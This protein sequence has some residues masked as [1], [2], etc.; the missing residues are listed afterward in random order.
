MYIKQQ[1]SKSRSR[2]LETETFLILNIHMKIISVI[3]ISEEDKGREHITVGFALRCTATV[4]SL[5]PGIGSRK[6]RCRD[7]LQFPPRSICSQV[8]IL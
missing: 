4:P 8:F 6:G 5:E 2:Y 7:R 3:P 1:T